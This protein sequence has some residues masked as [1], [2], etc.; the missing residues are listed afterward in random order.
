M[1][2]HI[3]IIA[4][5]HTAMT[6]IDGGKLDTLSSNETVKCSMIATLI[7][8]IEI[9][10]FPRNIVSAIYAYMAVSPL[11]LVCCALFV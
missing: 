9:K 6:C 2:S 10:I 7:L 11:I 5:A 3:P 8:R 4:S 1:A